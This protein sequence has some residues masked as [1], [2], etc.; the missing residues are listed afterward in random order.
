MAQ[1]TN[2]WQNLRCVFADY[3]GWAAVLKSGYLRLAAVAS[4]FLWPLFTKGEW[5]DKAISIIPTLLGLTLAAAAIL[6]TV[7]SD[8]FRERLGLVGAQRNEAAPIIR[9]LSN[10]SVALVV[11]TAALLYAVILS[12]RPFPTKWLVA[13]GAPDEVFWWI[14]FVL[15]YI[16]SVL[17]IY[18]ILLILGAAFSVRA[19]T[20]LYIRE[21]RRGAKRDIEP[22]GGSSGS[23]ALGAE[24][25]DND[26]VLPVSPTATH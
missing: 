13:R 4:L 22:P 10:F 5:A 3:G 6:T 16:G 15:G 24:A 26:Q 7:G 20:E 21:I 25:R 17:L 2:L 14:N 8:T 12:A 23:G 9:L 18:S 19:L 1:G 11:Q